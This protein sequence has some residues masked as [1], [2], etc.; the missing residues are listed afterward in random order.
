MHHYVGFWQIGSHIVQLNIK[1]LATIIYSS[2]TIINHCGLFLECWRNQSTCTHLGTKECSE[3]A[4]LTIIFFSYKSQRCPFLPLSKY[5]QILPAFHSRFFNHLLHLLHCV[6]KPKVVYNFT[7]RIAG[8][9]GKSSMIPKLKPFK[10]VL[11][12]NNL[13]ADLFICHKF[14]LPNA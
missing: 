13:L 14:F 11:T 8:K 9:F 4:C 5:Y 7:Y 12:I 6:V 3:S 2:I 1:T 10:F